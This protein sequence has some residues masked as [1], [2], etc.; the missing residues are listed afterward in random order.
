MSPKDADRILSDAGLRRGMSCVDVGC[1]DEELLFSMARQVGETGEV[2]AVERNR[3]RLDYLAQRAHQLGTNNITPFHSHLIERIVN[4]E[5][6]RF[7]FA[8]VAYSFERVEMKRPMLTEVARI[9]K[10]GGR[11]LV[12]ERLKRMPWGRGVQ[13]KELDMMLDTKVFRVD[14]REV[15]GGRILLLLTRLDTP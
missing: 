8:L 1:G 9:L 3:A 12:L 2:Y 15:G 10:V 6:R 13:E 5:S 14:R 4:M 7:D 11:A